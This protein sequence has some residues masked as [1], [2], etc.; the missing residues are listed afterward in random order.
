MFYR[1]WMAVAGLAAELG[2]KPASALATAL[3]GQGADR[4]LPVGSQLRGLLPEGLVRGSTVA[5]TAAGS[6]ATSLLLGLV[7]E[8]TRQGSWCAVVG[9]P[10]LSLAAAN[11][12][13]VALEHLMVVPHPGTEVATVAASLLDGFDVVAVAAAGGLAPSV[14]MQLSARARNTGAVLVALGAWPGAQLTLTVN[15]GV[16][17]GRGRLRCRRLSVAVS[18]RGSAARPRTEQVWLP[19]DPD[20]QQTLDQPDVSD[21]SAGRRL[22]VVA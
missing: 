2:V 12:M 17:F 15:E 7:A 9:V 19:A 10:R 18:G 5:V 22:R 8:P 3:A 20:V 14:S 11:S 13:G 1:G 16:W 6:G 4:V 21:A